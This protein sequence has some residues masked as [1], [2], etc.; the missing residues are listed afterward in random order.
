MKKK[1]FLYILIFSI[2]FGLNSCSTYKDVTIENISDIKI[3]GSSLE[4]VQLDILVQINNPNFY[5][6]N[7]TGYNLEISMENT[8]LGTVN[9][10]NKITIEGNSNKYHHLPVELKLKGIFSGA[11][12][13]F[14]AF[15]KEKIKIK[16]TGTVDAKA[17]MLDRVI[18]INIEKEVKLSK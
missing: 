2:S 9:S 7:I 11:I 12:A 10:N 13:F 14:S 17:M 16:I 4:S 18:D 15:T 8:Q 3:T 5:D 6:V 1:H